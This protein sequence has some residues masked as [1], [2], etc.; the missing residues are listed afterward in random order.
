[1]F[2]ELLLR[3]RSQTEI[4]ALLGVSHQRVQQ[5]VALA[6]VNLRKRMTHGF[7]IERIP[8]REERIAL[9]VRAA[10]AGP[11][12]LPE[13][14]SGSLRST[15]PSFAERVPGFDYGSRRWRPATPGESAD[16]GQAAGVRE[17]TPG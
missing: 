10:C 15:W 12:D 7:I 6:L 4:A 13:E 2:V 16:D 8:Q 3:G 5:V 14:S 17:E 1:M 11:A 9:A